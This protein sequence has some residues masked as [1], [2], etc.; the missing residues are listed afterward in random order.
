MKKYIVLFLCLVLIITGCG[1]K[2]NPPKGMSKEFYE[3]MLVLDKF[4]QKSIDAKFMY[5][6]G[7][8]MEF[9]ENK[10]IAEALDKEKNGELT[11]LEKATLEALKDTAASLDLYI[12]EPEKERW[13]KE[14]DKDYKRFKK[15][16]EP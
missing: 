8:Y 4:I 15:L 11:E 3:G 12:E 10:T 16:L 13:K 9:E 7:K 14:L 6:D 2:T 1:N 5:I